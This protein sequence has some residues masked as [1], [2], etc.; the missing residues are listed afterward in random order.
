MA[1]QYAVYANL[2]GDDLEQQAQSIIAS[3]KD[4]GIT[5]LVF[6]AS[7]DIYD[8]IPGKFGEWNQREI[9]VTTTCL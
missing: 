5:R 2:S 3:M 6:I 8:E 1:G 7:L 4:A 9:C